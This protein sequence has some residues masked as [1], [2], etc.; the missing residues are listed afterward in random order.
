MKRLFFTSTAIVF[1]AVSGQLHAE[2]NTGKTVANCADK[3]DA[4]DV[5]EYYANNPGAPTTIPARALDIPELHVVTGLP[6]TNR[7]GTSVTP[8]MVKD[9]WTTIDDWGE[10][11][12][13]NL[14]FT[15]GG[16]H[17][18]DFPSLVPVRQE[19]LF[20]G[21]IDIYADNGD[22]VH[23]HLW[24]K[25]ITAVHAFD[26]DGIDDNTRTR[27]VMFFAPEGFLTIG[28]YASITGKAFD[29]KAVDGF[30]RTWDFLA[31]QTQVCK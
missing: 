4:K 13:V 25:R 2:L 17:V 15:M 10:T 21:W 1:F 22:G 7:T 18:T 16:Q 28:V 14:I 24:L 29:Q 30:Q 9:I 3:G 20:D 11:T 31:A 27:G 8:D 19:D 26:I 12:K 6:S 23:G 5:V